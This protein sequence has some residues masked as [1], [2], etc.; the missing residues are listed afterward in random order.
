MNIK[1]IHLILEY[2]AKC[3]SSSPQ[4]N[5]LYMYILDTLASD[6]LCAKSMFTCEQISKL[7]RGEISSYETAK[8]LLDKSFDQFRDTNL[9]VQKRDIFNSLMAGN[10]PSHKAKLSNS[11]EDFE[12]SLSSV[13]A[14][15][16]MMIKSYIVALS[17]ALE[18]F[19]IFDKEKK[20]S[21]ELVT[22]YAL[23]IH[24]SI[25]KNLFYEEEKIHIDESLKQLAIVYIG[26]YYRSF[27]G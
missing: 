4:T 13:E 25:L 23:K 5:E 20:S 8:A 10:F 9:R 12:A 16:Y 27:Y 7:L 21:V 19:M 2:L 22:S 17:E 15:M 24:E 14:K 18:F 1:K 26:L 6:G 11:I 3:K